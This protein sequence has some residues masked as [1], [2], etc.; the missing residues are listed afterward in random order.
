[1]ADRNLRTVGQSRSLRVTAAP[2][3]WQV[4]RDGDATGA[5]HGS[6]AEA[7]RAATAAVRKDGGILRIPGKS[8]RT[9]DSLILGRKAAAKMNA[10]EGIDIGGRVKRDLETFDREE[11]GPEERRARIRETYGR[12]SSR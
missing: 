7:L 9:R 1:M 2:G 8:G 3:G 5:V 12:K 10:V 6:K 11:L 4:N